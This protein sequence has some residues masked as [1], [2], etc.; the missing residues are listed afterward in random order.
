MTTLTC[1]CSGTCNCSTQSI[2]VQVLPGQTNTIQVSPVQG[3][4][5]GVQ[6][7]QGTQGTQGPAGA[8]AEVSLAD[9]S[10]HHVQNVASSIWN[11]TH[12]LGF[13]PNITVVDSAGTVLEGDLEY[14]DLN[15][16]RVTF[17]AAFSGNAYL[18]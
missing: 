4:A 16:I 15:N 5:R 8:N 11:I 1:G 17:S 14:I 7:T 10:Y 13:Y 6:G 9:L 2:I 18:S 3:G 12:N